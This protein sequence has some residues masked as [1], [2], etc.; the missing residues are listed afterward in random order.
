MIINEPAKKQTGESADPDNSADD[1]DWCPSV[2]AGDRSHSPKKN[3]EPNLT[4]RTQSRKEK[5]EIAAKEHKEHKEKPRAEDAEGA[6][7]RER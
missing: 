1:A 2:V 4:Q 5:T 3:T 6:E 7:E